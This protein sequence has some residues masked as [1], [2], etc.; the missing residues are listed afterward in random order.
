MAKKFIVSGD[1]VGKPEIKS[2]KSGKDMMTF[3]ISLDGGQDRWDSDQHQMVKE[4][5]KIPFTVFEG[6]LYDDVYDTLMTEKRVSVCFTLTQHEWD[7]RLFSPNF[8][9]SSVL[10]CDAPENQP[11]RSQDGVSGSQN[12]TAA[13]TPTFATPTPQNS[14]PSIADAYDADIP[15]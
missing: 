6:R 8:R 2:T 5:C 12:G 1:L 4:E 9:V 3:V 7:G 10:P 13:Q 14:S 15:F 11:E